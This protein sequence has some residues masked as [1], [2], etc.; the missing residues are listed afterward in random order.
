[1][2][3][4]IKCKVDSVKCYNP[5]HPNTTSTIQHILR[6]AVMRGL[7]VSFY[8]P[9]V[10]LKN[11]LGEQ[12]L[13]RDEIKFAGRK[14]IVLCPV[15]RMNIRKDGH[16][17]MMDLSHCTFFI[18]IYTG[19]DRNDQKCKNYKINHRFSNNAFL[20]CQ[21]QIMSKFF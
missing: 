17:D 11:Q 14:G 1:M 2:V 10:S 12:G 13:F 15:E 21:E 6:G 3:C 16:P 18:C 4:C 19:T 20:N 5:S 9:S 8:L 7:K